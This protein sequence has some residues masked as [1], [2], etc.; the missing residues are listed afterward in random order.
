MEH[1]Q[2][3]DRV[4]F[5]LLYI[6]RRHTDRAATAKL[7]A[8]VPGDFNITFMPYFMSIAEESLTMNWSIK[9]W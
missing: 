2:D 1:V 9:S 6:L 8:L 7:A 4:I 5:K 3:P